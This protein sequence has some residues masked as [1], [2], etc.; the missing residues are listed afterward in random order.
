M[1]HS[2]SVQC[3]VDLGI[4]GKQVGRL[5]IPRSTNTGGWSHLF[6]PIATVGS[7]EGPT[8][9]VLGGNH[10]DEYEGQIAGLKL[11]RQLQPEQVHGRVII[12]PCLSPEASRA[13]TR[14]W[15]SGANFNR[16]FPGRSD[17]PPNELLADFL[18]HVLIPLSDVV[19]DIHSGGRDA[20]FVP[21]SHM[22]W[23]DDPAQRRQMVAGMRAWNTDYHYLYVDI[24]GSGLLP[25]EAERQGKLVITTELGGGGY[26]SPLMH[27]M[28]ERGLQNVLRHVGALVGEVE[29]RASMGLPEPVI[30]DARHPTDYLLA[31]ESGLWEALVDPGEPVVEG[32]PVGR[33]YFLERPECEPLTLVSPTNGV[34]VGVRAMVTTDQGDNV[35]VVGRVIDVSELQ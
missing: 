20:R 9:L 15:P 33:V 3:T 5:E 7:G 35:V 31:P 8:V 28:T 32:Q 1:T 2:T 22:H 27:R 6:I 23:V 21:C 13:G 12:I 16:S 18:T 19:I 25:V 14:L 34:I 10:G 17:G 26:T 11:I 30:L 29:T 24:A 4:T